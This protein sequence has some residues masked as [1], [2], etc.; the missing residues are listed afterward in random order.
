MQ[1]VRGCPRQW[2]CSRA[3]WTFLVVMQKCC[4]CGMHAVERWH[5][6]VACGM[7]LWECSPLQVSCFN[8]VYVCNAA[9]VLCDYSLRIQG[10]AIMPYMHVDGII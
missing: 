1:V 4:W 6:H 7:G 3:D 8:L 2:M 10:G 9:C 5:W